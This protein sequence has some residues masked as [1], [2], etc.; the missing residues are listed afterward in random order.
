MSAFLF[1]FIVLLIL[2]VGS[3]LLISVITKYDKHV[4]ELQGRYDYY[5]TTYEVSFD[6]SS[7]DIENL[8]EEEKAKYEAA[9][10]AIN[11]DNEFKRNY[12]YCI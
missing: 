2:A 12:S 1:D 9:S 6:I 7:E 5:S 4:D 10:K 8:S 11:E 3:A